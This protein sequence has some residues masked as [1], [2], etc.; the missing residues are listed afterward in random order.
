MWGKTH[1]SNSA[2]S[3]EVEDVPGPGTLRPDVIWFICG[4]EGP[5]PYFLLAWLPSY[6]HCLK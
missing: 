6:R 2:L 1:N 5:G 4:Q 3:R